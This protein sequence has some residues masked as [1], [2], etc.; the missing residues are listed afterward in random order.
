MTKNNYICRE[1]LLAMVYSEKVDILRTISDK[2]K[3]PSSQTHS[4]KGFQ[5]YCVDS[6][7]KER[8]KAVPIVLF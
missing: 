8:R 1:H 2:K 3:Q 7:V 6:S 5:E 4:F